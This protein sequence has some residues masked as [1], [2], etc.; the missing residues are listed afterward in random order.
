VHLQISVQKVDNICNITKKGRKHKSK[1]AMY[2]CTNICY[3]DDFLYSFFRAP[4][5]QLMICTCIPIEVIKTR[6]AYLLSSCFMVRQKLR[7]KLQI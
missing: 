6:D 7:D 1:T 4:F 5:V 2:L 3:L